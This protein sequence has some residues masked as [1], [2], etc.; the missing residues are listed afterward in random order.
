MAVK[1]KPGLLGT[2][3]KEPIQSS[4]AKV[5]SYGAAKA[6]ASAVQYAPAS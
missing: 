2:I 4:P 3:S 6:R 1:A 5:A